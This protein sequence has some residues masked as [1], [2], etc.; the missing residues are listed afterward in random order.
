MGRTDW[1]CPECSFLNYWHR[2]NCLSCYRQD[3]DTTKGKGKGRGKSRGKSR[4]RSQGSTQTPKPAKT[5]S[6]SSRLPDVEDACE[7]NK[8]ADEELVERFRMKRGALGMLRKAGGEGST[9][10]M[11][12]ER[13]ISQIELQRLA[14][15]PATQ[16]EEYVELK[17]FQLQE[18]ID[19]KEQHIEKVTEELNVLEMEKADLQL[20]LATVRSQGE[21]EAD[22]ADKPN[23]TDRP[24]TM[25]ESFADMQRC[26]TSENTDP[27]MRNL[28]EAFKQVMDAQNAATDEGTEQQDAGQGAQQ[29]SRG[30]PLFAESTSAAPA[31]RT[32]GLPEMFDIT[33]QDTSRTERPASVPKTP[34]Q[35]PYE[36]SSSAARQGGTAM[37]PFGKMKS[38]LQ[39]AMDPYSDG[40]GQ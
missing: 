33:M 38:P 32:A 3:A 21:A 29:G 6:D 27:T 25:R 37:Q 28:I 12:L 24:R 20:T 14:L 34:R 36:S 18:R 15:R 1:K 13:E 23:A 31:A 7:S 4:T 17:L 10:V 30:L 19:L 9:A 11:A 22:Q 40:Q 39:V 35:G 5:N 16:R 26:A 8:K 2:A